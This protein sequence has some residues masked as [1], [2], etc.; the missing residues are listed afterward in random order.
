MTKQWSWASDEAALKYALPLAAFLLALLILLLVRH[1]MMKWLRARS[2]GEGAIGHIVLETLRFP[3][4]LWSIAAAVQVGLDLSIFPPKYTGR[5]SNAI[6]AFLI[7]SVCMV[8]ASDRYL[9]ADYFRDYAE[10]R[11]AQWPG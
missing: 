3:S 2:R 9:E 8:L 6:L 1:G 5:A 4:L 7:V 11:K 10:F